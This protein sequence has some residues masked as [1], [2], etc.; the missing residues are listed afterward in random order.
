MKTGLKW[1]KI[2]K[3]VNAWKIWTNSKGQIEVQKILN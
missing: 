3:V 1:L 2:S